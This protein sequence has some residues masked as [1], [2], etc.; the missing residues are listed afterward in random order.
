MLKALS[1]RQPWA[2]LLAVGA[3]RVETRSGST[4]L[5]GEFAVHAAQ[6]WTAK[7][8]R[9]CR[10]EPFAAALARAGLQREELPTG[11]II[12]L[13]MIEDCFRFTGADAYHLAGGV[14]AL[15]EPERAFGDFT[16]GRFGFLTS[17]VRRL[18]MPVPCRGALGFWTV[19]PE[20]EVAVR[21]QLN[22]T[23]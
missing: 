11:A 8:Q 16:P 21:A 5:R 18:A 22:P 12:G 3:K 10:T 7:Q 4:Q 13:A 17:N 14:F 20:V 9:L 2:S 1:L 19:P 15:T 6:A 23:R